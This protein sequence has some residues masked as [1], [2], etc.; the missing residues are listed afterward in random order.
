MTDV[1]DEAVDVLVDAYPM[2]EL[3]LGMVYEMERDPDRLPYH[4]VHT[5]RI[6]EPFDERCFRDA[7][8][9]VVARHPVLRTAFALAGFSEPMQLVYGS[10]EVPISVADLRGQ[11]DASRAVIES[12]LEDERRTPLDVT[13]APLCR[14][15]VHVLSDDAFQWTF[16]EHHAILDGWSLACVVAEITDAY[17]TLLAGAEF[18]VEVPLGSTFRDF[19]VAERAAMS[20]PESQEFW[21]TRLAE[22]PDSRLPRWPAD[23]PVTL[24]AEPIAGQRH[25]HDE[26]RGY[27]SLITPLPATFSA[28]LR[29]VA[30]LSRVPLK[31]VLLAAHV[32]VLSL[33]TGSPDVVVGLTANGRLEEE[34]GTDACGLFVN[35]VPFRMELPDGSWR[36]LIRAVFDT[37]NELLPHRRYPMAALQ[38][39][40]G[41]SQLVET[42]FVYTDFQQLEAA[43]ED[44]PAGPAGD[45]ARTHFALVVAFVREP[46]AEGLR[47]EFEYDARAFPAVQLGALRDYYLRTLAE[48]VAD[49]QT[50]HRW[51]ALLG[52]GERAL[53]ESWNDNVTEVSPT[54]VHRMIEEWVAA[55]PDAVALVSGEQSLTYAELNARANRVARRLR[56]VGVS[57]DTAVGVCIER[58]AEMVVCWLAVLKAGGSYVPLDPSV[59]ASR[60]EFMLTQAKAPLVLTAGR[61][62]PDGPW[63]VLVVGEELWA[64]GSDENL[65]GGAGPDHACYVIF[66]SGSTGQPKGVVTRHRNV[67]ELLHGGDTMTVRPDDTVLQIAPA[68]FDVSTFEVWAP[69]VNGAR[70]VVAPRVKYGPAE[71]ADWVARW[72]VTVLHATASLF[73]LLVDHEPQLF[74]GLRRLLTGSET[75]SPGHVVRILER[76]PDLEVLNCWGPTET[77]TISVAGVFRNGTVPAGPLPLGVPLVNTEVWVLDQ[78]GMPVPIGSPGELYVSGPC[79]ARGYLGRPDLTAERF[80]PHPFRDGERL[81]RTGD[82]GRWSVDGVVEFLGRT[83]HMVKVRGY[84]VEL[85]EVESALRDYPGV[86][87]CVVVTRANNTEGVDLVAYLAMDSAVPTSTEVRT[88]LGQRLP[89][90]MVPRLVVFLD[91]LPLTPRAKVDRRALPEPEDVR[92]DVAQEYVAPIGDVEELLAEIWCQVLGV[93]RVGRHDNLF[94]LGGDSIRSIQILGQ[95]REAG[96]TAS[97][98]ALL[99]DPTPAGLAAALTDA[100]TSPRSQP[101]S[102]VA[103]DDRTLLPAGL[104]DAY[105]M[106]ELQVGMVYEMERDP[107]RLPYHNV[108]TLRISG[109]F[110]ERRFRDAVARVVARHPV[111][112]TSF[113]LAGFGE[114]MQLVHGTAEVPITVIDLRAVS[115]DDAVSSYVDSERRTPLDLTVAP[116]CRMGVHVLSDNAFQWT[117][118]FQHAIMD[119][120]SLAS[121]VEEIT[122]GYRK[123]VAGEEPAATP[124][125]STYRDFIAAERDALNSPESQE[126]WRDRLA[127]LPDSR[128]PR[129]PDDRPAAL[130]GKPLAGDRHL[131]DEG[132]G[133]GSLISQLPSELPA[134]LRALARECAVP[135]KA[136]LLAAHAKVMSLVT[137]SPDVVLGLTANGRLEEEGG[138]DAC[139]LFVNTVPFRMELPDGDWRDLILAVFLAENE[140]MPHR[141]YPIAALQRDLGGSPF[142]TNFVYTEFR[143]LTRLAEDGTL[144]PVGTDPAISGAARTNFPL[145][146]TFSTEPGVDGLLVELDY[147]T[148]VLTPDQVLR[149]RDYYVRVLSDMVADPAAGHRWV[150][151]L[152]ADE[153][154]LLESWNANVG[155]VPPAPVYR[156][157]E[158]RVAAQPDAVAVESGGVSLTYGELNARANRMARRLRDHGVGPDVA[159][160]LCVDRSLAT[161]TSLLA[162]LKAGGVYVP[163]EPEFPAERMEFMLRQADVPLVLAD[164]QAAGRVPAGSWKTLTVNDK[165]W[166]KG[167]GENLSGGAGPDHGC[168]VIF[169]SGSTGQPKGVV[170]RHRNVTELLHGAEF[171]TL[172]PSDTL[173]QLAPL[174]FDNSTFE[175]W[176]PL[177]GGARLVLAPSVRYGPAEIARWVADSGVTVLHATASLFALLVDHEPQLFDGLRRFLT[178]S[179]TVSPAH[180]VRILERCPDMELVNC[181]GPTETTTFSVCGVYRHGSVP[182]GALPLGKPLINT[183]VWVLD[184]AGMPAPVGTP[185]ELYVSGPCLARGYLGRPAL[186]A[187]R[188]VPHPFH[189]GERLYR[190]G[191]RGRWSV[192]GHIEFLGRT[193]HMVK[194]RGYRV[195]LGEVETALRGHPDIR[196]CVVITR[197]NNAAG[198]DL[199]AYLV[200]DGTAPTPVY[201]RSWLGQRLPAYMVPRLFVFLDALPLTPRAKVDRR[202][203]PEPEAARSDHTREYVAPVG[204]IEEHLAGIWSRVLGVERVGRDDNF[205][206]LGGDSIRSIQVVGWARDAGF[207]MSL[208][209]L[210]DAPTLAGLAAMVTRSDSAPVSA[211]QPFSLVSEVDS[212]LLPEGLADAYPMAQLQVGMVYEMERDR[213]RN[214]YHNVET[215]RLA[216]RFDESC[217]REAV[218]LVVARHPALRTSFDLV[219]FGEPMQ[220]VHRAAEVPFVVADLRRVAADERLTELR[221]YVRDQQRTWFD[222]SAAPLLRMAVHVL[223][224]EAFHWTITE[225]HAILDGWSMVSTLTEITEVYHRLL[226]G[227]RP[228]PEPLRSVYRDFIAA[229]RAALD[230]PQSQEFWR[231]RLSAAPDRRILKWDN[232]IPAEPVP[233]ERHERDEAAGHGVLIT[234]LPTELVRG[235]EEFASRAAV[236]LKTVVLAAHLKVI[237]LLTGSTDVLIGLTANGRL[238]EVDG[239]EARGLFLNTVPLRVRLPEGSW[240]DLARTVLRAERDLLPH[241]R[242][243]IAALQRDFGGEPL[244]AT[245][246]TYNNF[247]QVVPLAED[248][249]LDQSEAD[250]TV[251]GVART[252]FPLDITFSHE[253]G[254]DVL[255][256]GIDY[257]LQDLSDNQVLRLRDNHLRA[258]RAMVSDDQAHHRGSSLLGAEEAR[259]LAGWQGTDAPVSGAPV[260][261]SLRERVASWPDAVAVEAGEET[262]T[263]ARLDAA[264]ET[265]ARRLVAAGVRRGDIVGLHLRPGLTAIVAVWGVWKAGGAFLPLDPDLPTTRLEMMLEDATPSVVVSQEAAPGSWPTI[266][267]DGGPEVPDVALPRVSTQDLAYVMFTSGSTGRPK[268]VMIDHG[269]LAN[270]AEGLLLPRIR[271]AGIKAGQH[272]RVLTGTSAFISDFFLEQILP[273]LDGHRLLVLTGTEARDPRH[274]IELA[275]NPDTAVDL[276][277]A[278]TSQIQLMVDA[279]LLDAPHPPRL[280]AIGGE[281]C[282]PDL[283][284]TLRSHPRTAAHNTYGPAEA[285]V[286]ATGSDIDAHDSPVIGRPYGNVRAYLVDDA[287]D[288]VP[289]G[290]VGEIVVGGPGV[291][292]GYVRRPATTAAAF[293]PDPWG[294]PGSRLYRTGD[295]GRYNE[296]GQIEYLG[297]ND[298]QIKILGQRIEPE[299]VESALRSHPTIEAAAVSAHRIGTDQRPRLVAHIVSTA[300]ADRDELR[301]YL[302]DRLPAAAVPTV[303]LTVDELPTTAG[304]KLDRKALAMPDDVEAQLPRREVVAPRTETER[305]IAEIWQALLGVSQVSVHDDFLAMGGHSLLAVRLAMRVSADLGVDLPLHEVFARP[306]VAGQAELIDERG[307]AGSIQPIPRID[308]SG[309]L[310]ASHAQERQW[311][312]WQLAPDSPNYHVP[313]GYEVHGDLDLATFDAA[314]AALV[315]R[316]ESLRTTLHLDQEGHV[317]QRIAPTWDGHVTVYECDPDS[318]PTLID[319]AAWRP[320]DLSEGPVL[321]VSVLR[322]APNKQVVLFV[323]HHVAVD[324]WSIE[325]LE[326]DFWALYRGEALPP[327]GVSYADYTAW[328]RE[329]VEHQSEADIAYWR[330]ALDGD[331][332]S[333]PHPRT[334]PGEPAAGEC[335][336]FVPGQWLTGLDQ[337]RAQAGATEFMVFLAVYSLLLARQ[338]GERDFTVGIPVSGRS[339]PDLASLVGFF[340]NTLALRLTVHP[341][342]DFP[343]H[344]KRVRSVVLGAF[345]HQEAPFEHVVRAVA[346]NRAEGANPLFRTMFAFA[347]IPGSQLADRLAD[348]APAGLTLSDLRLTGGGNLF[349]LSVTATRTADGLHLNLEY[350]TG[351][352]APDA[353]EELS[354]AYADLL[355]TLSRSPKAAVSELLRANQRERERIAAWTGDGSEPAPDVAMTE[356]LRDRITLWPNAIAVESGEETLTFAQLD[357]DS[358]RLARRLVA[359]GVRRGDLVGLHLRPGI[360]VVVSIWA[361]WKAGGAFLPLDPELPPALLELVLDDA[362]PSVVVSPETVPGSWP[363]ISPDDDTE[364]PDLVLPRVSASDLAYVMFTSGSTGRPKG[365]MIDHRGLANFAERL[366]LPRLRGVGMVPGSNARSLTGTSAYISDFFLEQFL[367]MLDGHRLV[368]APGTAARDP[369]YLVE[370]AQNPDTAVDVIDATTSQVQLM[371]EAGLLDAPHPPRLIAFGGEACPP[372]LWQA[373]RSRPWTVA[374]NTYGPAEAAV[375]ATS[376]DVAEHAS[377]LIGRP[378]GNIRTYL[379]AADLGL[380]PPGAVGEI[381]IGGPGVGRGYLNRPGATAAVFVPDPWG[382]PGS[383]LYR[384]GDLGR[385]TEDGQIEF[386]GRNDHQVKILGQR[387]ELEE[388]E[389]ALRSH[390][391]IEA[392]A[393]SAHRLGTDRGLQLI[394]HLVSAAPVDRDELRAYLADRLPAAAVPTV[395]LTVD[396]L[397]LTAS[398]KLDRRALTVPDDVEAQLA[399]RELVEPRTETERRIAE[400]WQTLLSISHVGVYDDFFALGGHSLLAVRLAMRVSTEV[401]VD[402][403]L[404]EVLAR[405]TVAGQAELIDRRGSLGSAARI[406]RVDQAGDLPASHA[407]ERQWYLWQLAPGSATYNVPWGY[408]I[409]G[410]LDVGALG[411][412]VDALLERHESLRTTLHLDADGHVVQRVGAAAATDLPVRDVAEADLP[413]LVEQ[414]AERPF[415]L[416]TGPVLRVSVWRTAPDR[417]KVLFVA[418][419]V[420]VDEWSIGILERELWARYQGD[421]LPPLEVSYRDYAVWHRDLVERQAEEDLA[422]WRQNLDGATASLPYS[423]GGETFGSGERTRTIAQ[424]RL[425][426]LDR[427]RAKAGA[428]EF[429]VFLAV[430]SLVLARRSR[431]RDLTVGIPVSGRSHPDLAS[432]V[433]FF[434]NTLALRLTVDPD[435]DFLAHLKRVRSVV[436]EAFAHQETPFEHVVRAVA[437]DRA[438]GTNPLFRTAFSFLPGT[439]AAERLAQLDGL[440]VTDLPIPGGDNHFDLMLGTTRTAEGLHLNLEFSQHIQPY[441]AD[442][443]LES[444]ADLLDTLAQSPQATVSELL[445]ATGRER[446]RIA[447]WTGT[448]S[449]PAC[450]VPVHELLRDRTTLWP[451]AIA[452]ESGDQT[453]TFAQLGAYSENLA[454]RLAGAGVRRGDVVGLH[455]RPGV[456]AV[457]AVWAVWKA[458]GA[459]LPLDPDLPPARLELMLADAA[460]AVVVSRDPGAVPGNVPTLSP[461]ASADV[462][463]VVLPLV[464]TKDLAGVL[465]TSGST[466]RPKGVLLE[467]GGLATFA[468][469]QLL[470]RIRA[471]GVGEHAR[472]VTGTTAFISDFFLEQVLPLLDGHRLL[473]LAGAEGRDPRRLVEL[474]QDPATAVAV[475]CTTTSQVQLMVDA[476]LLDAPHPPKLIEPAGEACPPDLWNALRSRPGVAANNI[477]GPSETTVDATRADIGAFGSPVI[478]R[479]Y[480]STRLYLVDDARG[481]VPPGAVGEIVIGGPGVGRGYARRPDATAAAF[482][483]DPWGEPG[484]R[485]YRTGDLGRYD[486]H[487]QIEFLGRNDHQVKILGQRVEPEEVEAALRSHPA[488]DAAAIS[489]H[490]LGADQRL[491]L[492]AHLVPAEPVDQDELRAFLTDRLPSAA[493]PTVFVTVDALPTT[494]GGKLDRKA[495]TLPEQALAHR[496]VVAPRTETE[497]RVAEVWQALLGV[498]QIGVHD[499]FFVLG[500]HSLLAVRL[501]MRVGAELG[502]DLPLHEVLVRPTVAG[503]AELIDRG[504]VGSAGRIPHVEL[505]GDLPASHAQERQWFLWQLAPDSP[506]YNVPWGYDIRGDLDIA[507]FEAAVDALIE[508]H[509]SLRTTLHLDADGHVVQRV[510]AAGQRRIVVRE[511]TEAELPTLVAQESGRPFELSAGPVLRVTVWRTAPDRHAVLFVAHHAAVDEWSLEVL[512]RELWALYEGDALPP[513]EVR[514]AD[515]AVWHRDA[516]RRQAAEELAYWR[517]TLDGATSSWPQPHGVPENAGE[518]ES[519]VPVDWLAG[520][521]QVRAQA[522]ATEFMLF[523]AVY[524]LL[525]ARSSGERDVTVGT[526]VSGRMHAD[527][528]PLVGFFVNTLALRVTVDPRDDFRTHLKRVRSVVLE[529]FAHQEAPFEHVVRAVAPDRADGENPLFRTAFSFLP[530]TRTEHPDGV[531]VGGLTVRDLPT[532]SGDNHFDLMLRTAHTADGLHVHLEYSTGHLTAN[533]ADELSRSFA[534]LL[535]TVSHSPETTVSEL[536]RANQREQERMAGWTG[537]DSEPAPTGVVHELLRDRSALW[538]DAVAIE[539]DD[540]SLT[541]AQLAARS[542]AL[543]RRLVGAGVRRGDIVGLRLRPSVEAILAVWA[544]WKAGGAFVPLDPDLP[545]ARLE[546]ML[547]DAAPAMVITPDDMSGDAPDVALPDLSTKDL[548][549]V[550]Y[551]SGSTGRPKGVMLEHGNLA[552]W[553]EHQLLPRMHEAGVGAHAR[554]VT[555]TSA[556]ISDFFFMQMLPLLGGHRLRV[557]SGIEGRDPRRL[558]DLAKDPATAADVV[559]TTNSQVQLLVEAGLLDAP[560]PPRLIEGAGEAC[561][562]D[563]WQALASRPDIVARNIYGPCEATIDQTLADIRADQSVVIGRPYGNVRTYLVDDA[564]ELVPPGVAGEIVIGGP[565]VGRG[566]HNRPGATAAVFVPDPW[567]APG[568]RLY[569][570]GDLGRYTED[571]QLEFLGR[572]D[573]QVKILGQRVEP[574]EVEAALRSHPKIN[575]AAVSAHKPDQRPQLV[576]H[577]VSAEPIERDEL[578][579]YLADRLPTAAIPTVFV[580][581]DALPTTV[582]GKLDRKALTLPDDHETHRDVVAPRTETERRI[583]EVWQDLLGVPTVG[584]HDDFFALGGHSLLAIRL[585]MQLSRTLGVEIPL[586]D[587]YTAPTIAEQAARLEANTRPAGGRGV[588][589]LGG[590]AGARPLVLVHPV[591][592]T[593]FGYRDLLGELTADFEAFGVHGALDGDSGAGDLAAMARRYA[594][595]LAMVV[596]DREPVIA[597]WSA[598]GV[599]AH[600][601]ARILAERGIRV[602]R[603]VLIDSDPHPVDATDEDYRLDIAI[604]DELRREVAEHG[605][606]PLLDSG[607]ADRLFATLG[608]E[609]AAVAELDGP[610]LAGFMTFWR[611]MFTG[612]A[613]HHPARFAGPAELI[614]AGEDG[615]DPLI[616]AWRELTGALTVTHADGDHFQ[617]LRRPWVK[618]VADAVRGAAAQIGD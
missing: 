562:P 536:L 350:S 322:T 520:L 463:D 326:R 515:Y 522:G 86:R 173:L 490:R 529:A 110:D 369:R 576:A 85:G 561:P 45:V 127:E 232:E 393:V 533:A 475:V 340:V 431:E 204:D 64:D 188:F 38:R 179:E 319:L 95:V 505:S 283:W 77:T 523:F 338:S 198:V 606:R 97:L 566:Y 65:D 349:D 23:R 229:E 212:R 224:D 493:V 405:P 60:L 195:E 107:D 248:G 540:E 68:A 288:L 556:F 128:L 584:V 133:Y 6:G 372:D 122:G 429:M 116:L 457:L 539:S 137:G 597:G 605:P 419:H 302:T 371:V 411:V 241:R 29:D 589:A 254:E 594:G 598:G 434:V 368:L 395:F 316:H 177:V 588:V 454:R 1:I 279:G 142:E 553:T 525:V 364:V 46:G 397:P 601:I 518:S 499:D 47:L 409:Q 430:Y 289:A 8:A 228:T 446:E 455:L 413:G 277:D 345:A 143:Q 22:L 592:G 474:A 154:A 347:A 485:L 487:G 549:C 57:C 443:L 80:V 469:R 542:D 339:H 387:V 112:R 307:P 382:E 448:D 603:L 25:V 297:R 269:G 285:A 498:P 300:P 336:R 491:Q 13:V 572:N 321:R 197:A 17:R 295:L 251:S 590:T 234:T 208:Q 90:Y 240:H 441:A 58:S 299:D 270:F 407:Q 215:V 328:H 218:A 211:T 343:T 293:V 580:S 425:A 591:G 253:P 69:L 315:Q 213:A 335:D 435:D 420:A 527:F 373:L 118:T 331:T 422:Y 20:S 492:V 75:V 170:T 36:E 496:E 237:S 210:L 445:H 205:F 506:A 353:A 26:S 113:A 217:F 560:H 467:H 106:A 502:V 266:S 34:G 320:F 152:G 365:V 396:S 521:D 402:L 337:V 575:A 442:E 207:A 432:L 361:V 219:G 144:D 436:L 294:E 193:D 74:D 156:M 312:L 428:T 344:L 381:V 524:C 483:P 280:I 303:I 239:A 37:E 265:M 531:A 203:L 568:S 311:F 334:V 129:W 412:A 304:G 120:W 98:A 172:N 415:N 42:N 593:L 356:L 292:R 100:D 615:R 451:N 56:E 555:G 44:V 284:Q 31:A 317:L 50:G 221:E 583:A 272:L 273:T 325:I 449:L 579:A 604:L 174:S 478:G 410:D 565:G 141:R 249:T 509:E 168:Y 439:Q 416:S 390:F 526:P 88:W 157:F 111:L 543:A 3:Q 67:T 554:V 99:A 256:L 260:H 102:L 222:L 582:G 563:I 616:T 346:P 52:P 61:G 433:G 610:T 532:P 262:L 465:F 278:T 94:D 160:A 115:E 466:G 495:L 109:S 247:H 291:G 91:S 126:Y 500:G 226:A 138:T 401:G 528:A 514:Y 444:F 209:N 313:W 246:F 169:T 440:T 214:P 276:I 468:E 599:I 414:E 81:Y 569:R 461:D 424:E 151:L 238:E 96:L 30:R 602:R 43:G 342:D 257:S 398:G 242:Y 447:A 59:P 470:P 427:I 585:T 595:E 341:E 134:R 462:P 537:D 87:E 557:L 618:A 377:P 600:E 450:D 108:H 178:G 155:E 89:A 573:R 511:A 103:D 132:R 10:V 19:I 123:L 406:P 507:A 392:A 497:R 119:G 275:Q 282:P 423:S 191:D 510:G 264:S 245:N 494:A 274:L 355:H 374:H 486:E 417:H 54:P 517:Q 376:A 227:E 231:D 51:V 596:G 394:A 18:S 324:E 530:G 79:L 180:A 476:G 147:H 370:L 175:V 538:P 471:A 139:G 512:E 609:A 308:A 473:V 379:V 268:G 164:A 564:L 357:T 286:D 135:F 418:H 41:G 158:E 333:W 391:A 516:V 84:R 9:R 404:H 551:T 504:S 104:A 298:H 159:V 578:R 383:R 66:T 547:D 323:A 2:S 550:M 223:S 452:V 194:V 453:L 489:A 367:P 366:L 153:R 306:T 182:A 318:L 459:F 62:V 235:L 259:L 28:K 472:V 150:S 480:G 181:W 101:F 250:D 72:D 456:E 408:E 458:G 399:R 71:I 33:V 189:T 24:T 93:D 567:G 206:D 385:Y 267:P 70:L 464:S 479:P 503:Q 358:D 577:L 362:A 296:H 136:V 117:F 360:A 508:R 261:E 481:L 176:A 359:A 546:L 574:E 438:D 541:F 301:A 378:Y 612:L 613:T 488:V 403:P 351:H 124:P 11:G 617:L 92:P 39:E 548:A 519:I 125:R 310:P 586:A 187:E 607:H 363:T 12:F 146:I 165:L 220:L 477:Y 76:C 5:L 611:D 149:Y 352:F 281:A 55:A 199:V 49:P 389:A 287:L 388:V 63:Q 202:A 40:L 105:P 201:M 163:L 167:S 354:Q 14:M 171:L 375:D 4:N 21:R 236:P 252:N 114:P 184:D 48:M 255:L 140:F 190:T 230:S 258:L 35:T 27:G 482:V 558:V 571:G 225:H 166:S 162:I 305:R 386:L 348:N 290:S 148:D 185:G 552:N 460:P 53:L 83:D 384:T 437:P 608:V 535:R 329:L 484:S 581:L 544:V 243:P 309:D 121:V 130:A 587:L 614:V 183:Q 78:T 145:D 186:T 332:S 15:G 545:P 314:V 271:G 131:H 216:G 426:G 330:D 244:F 32:K 161:I 82:R 559:C 380:V 400:I 327:L 421:A 7:V 192:D 263:F 16:T 196:E 513:L 73:A 534:D 570:T 200:A 233:G 501:A